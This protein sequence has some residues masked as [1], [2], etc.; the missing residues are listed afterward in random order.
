METKISR[1]H[2][3]EGLKEN[4]ANFFLI[5]PIYFVLPFAFSA[6]PLPKDVSRFIY[7]AEACEHLAGEFDGELPQR[8]QDAILKDI[9]QYCKV[10]QNQL[11]ILEV[12]YKGNGNIMKVIQ[13]HANDAVT[14]YARE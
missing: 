12:K 5:V 14:S 1:Q 8:Q 6:Q 11:R 9:H 4:H 3:H 13:R 7:N 2:Q 10:A